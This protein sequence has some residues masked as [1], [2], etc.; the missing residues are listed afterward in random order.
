LPP[1][2]NSTEKY[3]SPKDFKFSTKFRVRLYFCDSY[4][5]IHH[6]N[7]LK[8]LEDTRVEY[9]RGIGWDYEEFESMGRMFLVADSYCR[10]LGSARRDDIITV[11][12]RVPNY[13]RSSAQLEY[14]ITP[15]TDDN[16]ILYGLITLVCVDCQT[17]RPQRLPDQLIESIDEF[18]STGKKQ[19]RF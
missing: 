6:S 1:K 9:F 15:D 19:L 7:Y 17:R 11:Y 8:I 10:H 5:I 13:K 12:C 3:P 16:L 18:E 2:S 14:L 4:S